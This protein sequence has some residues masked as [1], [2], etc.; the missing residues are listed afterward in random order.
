M[1]DNCISIVPKDVDS[2][3]VKILAERI[4]KWL[5]GNKIVNDVESDCVLNLKGFLPGSN[6]K[7]A[8]EDSDIQLL[9]LVNNGVEIITERQVWQG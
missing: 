4:F 6:Y 7:Y 2:S 1:G 3:E 5:T 9:N 8:V